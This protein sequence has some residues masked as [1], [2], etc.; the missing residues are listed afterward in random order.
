M[1]VL[2]KLYLLNILAMFTFIVLESFGVPC[3]ET[4]GKFAVF[5]S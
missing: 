5:I 4:L 1:S 3:F 2:M